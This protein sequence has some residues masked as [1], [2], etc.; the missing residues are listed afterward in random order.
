MKA[1]GARKASQR[2][3]D[4]TGESSSGRRRKFRSLEVPTAFEV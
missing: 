4:V 2:R 1:V 3:K